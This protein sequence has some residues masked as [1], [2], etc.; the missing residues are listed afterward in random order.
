MGRKIS[1]QTNKQT[2]GSI[3]GPLLFLRYINDIVN[4]IGSNIRIFADDTNLFLVVEKPNTAAETLNSDLEK[5]TQ[6]ANTWLV[7]FNQAK[8]ESLL[9]SRKVIQPVHPSSYNQ[10]QI[11]KE[12]ENHTH[13]GLY[14][15]KDG[16]WHTHM[17]YI[18][19]KHDTEKNDA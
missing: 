15:S 11:I 1:N 9:I 17:N 5:K 16:T 14:F 3:L 12:V 10:N 8:T 4:D 13:F 6:W 7:K 19:E 18:K 2:H